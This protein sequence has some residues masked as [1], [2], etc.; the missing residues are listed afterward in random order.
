MLIKFVLIILNRRYLNKI[1]FDK[2]IIILLFI[3][4]VIIFYK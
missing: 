2:I 3:I 4:I 1:V